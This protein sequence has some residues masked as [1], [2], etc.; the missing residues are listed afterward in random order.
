MRWGQEHF[1]EARPQR[2]AAPTASSPPAWPGAWTRP[3]PGESEQITGSR[4]GSE[5]PRDPRIRDHNI[6]T[7][8]QNQQTLEPDRTECSSQCKRED[9]L[10]LETIDKFTKRK[11]RLSPHR[12]GKIL[13]PANTQKAPEKSARTWKKDSQQTQHPNG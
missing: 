8:T 10:G 5:P 9:I 1:L 13:H 4:P 3:L 6:K 7:H 12:N 2:L 11:D